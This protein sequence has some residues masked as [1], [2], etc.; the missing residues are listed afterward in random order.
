MFFPPHFLCRA[1]RVLLTPYLLM[2][3]QLQK[4]VHLP[5]YC[6]QSKLSISENVNKTLHHDPSDR[7]G[8]IKRVPESPE[9]HRSRGCGRCPVPVKTILIHGYRIVNYYFTGEKSAVSAG[10]T[11]K[12]RSTSPSTANR[13]SYSANRSPYICPGFFS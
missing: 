7:S 6:S 8:W 13:M 1:L 3:S 2:L 11:S 4:P 10:R 5:V 12:T 9:K